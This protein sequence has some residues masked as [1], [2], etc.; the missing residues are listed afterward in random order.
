MNTY[1]NGEHKLQDKTLEVTC[2][3][4]GCGQPGELRSIIVLRWKLIFH[5]FSVTMWHK[6]FC[7]IN[8]CD[9]FKFL[10]DPKGKYP[11][12]IHYLQNIPSKMF[13]L[14]YNYVTNFRLWRGAKF[15]QSVCQFAMKL[16]AK[17][18]FQ[19]II[20]IAWFTCTAYH[21]R[22]CAK[23]HV[24]TRRKKGSRLKDSLYKLLKFSCRFFEHL[25]D[26][27]C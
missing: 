8:W 23:M 10:Q 24:S 11:T 15:K 12:K 21:N 9:F 16:K 1:L 2:D 6:I 18:L 26:G 20:Q 3:N 19:W 5:A 4:C 22:N 25:W 27:G 13:I 17:M 7:D 14:Y